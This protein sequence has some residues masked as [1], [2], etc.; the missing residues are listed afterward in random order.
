MAA[1]IISDSTTRATFKVPKTVT[2]RAVDFCIREGNW[3]DLYALFLGGGG[4]K[5][6]K[7]DVG[8]LATGCDAS[9]VRLNQV[10]IE[11]NVPDLYKFVSTL[12]KH[13]API[14]H[15]DGKDESALD[16]ALQRKKYDVAEMLIER[17]QGF[18]EKT[19]YSKASNE[20][21]SN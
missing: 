17:G 11:D 13:K 5:K 16:V 12:L 1:F 14:V 4:A 18:T 10:I 7:K 19:N 20:K 8:G 15:D 21:V 3:S 2:Q 6:F 9:S